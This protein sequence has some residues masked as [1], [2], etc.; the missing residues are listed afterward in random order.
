MLIG[1]QIDV[2]VESVDG[3][4]KHDESFGKF[5][6]CDVKFPVFIDFFGIV[7]G[8]GSIVEVFEECNIGSSYGVDHGDVDGDVCGVYVVVVVLY[9]YR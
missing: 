3:D 7:P 2:V 4:F 1:V 6:V 5:P 8:A 9:L